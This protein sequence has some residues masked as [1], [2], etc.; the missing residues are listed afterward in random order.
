MISLTHWI[1]V[2]QLCGTPVIILEPL[3]DTF[4][5][6]ILVFMFIFI[7]SND[8]KLLKWKKMQSDWFSS[9]LRYVQIYLFQSGW[10]SSAHR[11]T[12]T[13][14]MR[15]ID[16]LYRY[17]E[18]ISLLSRGGETEGQIQRE[19]TREGETLRKLNRGSL[20]VCCVI[21]LCCYLCADAE[22]R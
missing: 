10:W 19:S 1:F 6:L 12:N 9:S 7:F 11:E 14:H 17:Y 18:L 8:V 2:W 21:V 5:V 3:C 20:V 4:L 15:E 22:W 16:E 13:A